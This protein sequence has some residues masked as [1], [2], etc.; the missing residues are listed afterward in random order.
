MRLFRTLY[1]SEPKTASSSWSWIWLMF[2]RWL[3]TGPLATEASSEPSSVKAG[4]AA[5]TSGLL[6]RRS[7]NA[8]ERAQCSETDILKGNMPQRTTVSC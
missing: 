8:D 3:P 6:Q 1:C 7:W 2:R 4:I 5:Q